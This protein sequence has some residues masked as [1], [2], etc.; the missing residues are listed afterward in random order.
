MD[1]L[2]DRRG[3]VL[4]VIGT[5]LRDE[6]VAPTLKEICRAVGLGSPSA[7]RHHVRRLMDGGWI[8]P[9]PGWMLTRTILPTPK[10][11]TWLAQHGVLVPGVEP[12]TAALV[13][14]ARAVVD[15]PSPENYAALA[16]ALAQVAA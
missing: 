8:R 7:V 4:L 6:G 15:R 2:N 13:S 14:A 10:G 16:E 3:E 12:K 11:L 1:E 9:K 5:W